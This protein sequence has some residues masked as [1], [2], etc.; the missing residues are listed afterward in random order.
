M[1]GDFFGLVAGCGSRAEMDR[2]VREFGLEVMS[3][4][5]NK[6][7]IVLR[8]SPKFSAAEVHLLV[9]PRSCQWTSIMDIKD[10]Q[11]AGILQE[12]YVAGFKV[13]QNLDKSITS[14]NDPKIVAGYRYPPIFKHLHLHMLLTPLK[15]KLFSSARWIPHPSISPPQKSS[16]EKK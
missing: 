3:E 13:L 7:V 8:N 14:E 1:G 6:A 4:T 10:E 16:T 5:E 15:H 9:L 12:M 2:V 11:D